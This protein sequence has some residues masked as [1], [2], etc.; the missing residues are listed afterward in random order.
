MS[1]TEAQINVT[2]T[3]H[4]AECEIKGFKLFQAGKQNKQGNEVILLL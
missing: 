4:R 1:V 2:S 3:K